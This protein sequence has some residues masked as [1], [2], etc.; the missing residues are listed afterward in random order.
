[1]N[2]NIE[3]IK[4]AVGPNLEFFAKVGKSFSDLFKAARDKNE[5]H[6]AL[7]LIPEMR[8]MQDAGWSTAEESNRAFHEYV[9]FLQT[10]E[11]NSFRLRVALSFYC[12]LAEARLLRNTEKHDANSR[13]TA[14]RS[15]A[16]Q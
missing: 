11:H 9:A 13:R 3:E 16:I 2:V 14:L 12:H 1:M 6:F 4:A 8:G 7:A 10:T 5:L 15:V